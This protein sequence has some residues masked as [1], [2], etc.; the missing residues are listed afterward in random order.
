MTKTFTIDV[1]NNIT[2]HAGP[3]IPLQ[4]GEES[5]ASEQ[6]LAKLAAA[7][8]GSRVIEIWNSIGGVKPVS[9][10]A[11]KAT[12][13]KRIWT[14]I[15]KLAVAEPPPAAEPKTR[16]K[17]IKSLVA[18][19]GYSRADATAL[20]SAEEPPATKP[21]RAKK[22]PKGARNANGG[23][24]SGLPREGS[25]AS[26]VLAML[27]REGGATLD[28]IMTS[29]QWQP[30][31]TRALLSAGGAFTKKFGLTVLSQKVGDQRRYSIAG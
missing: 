11:N 13:L 30:H 9:K 25:K 27:K 1:E 10:F 20:A 12:G 6:Q 31:T 2:A 29:M 3:F 19:S 21:A 14:E 5:F 16:A 26:Q 24:P 28:E 23:Q 7:W 8:A 18:D 15:Q 22:A 17:R 4:A